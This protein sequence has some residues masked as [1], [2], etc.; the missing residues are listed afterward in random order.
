MKKKV[1]EIE[2]LSIKSLLTELIKCLE[3][4]SINIHDKKILQELKLPVD[5]IELGTTSSSI[6]DAFHENLVRWQE[7]FDKE[8]PIDAE[9]R[10]K[11]VKNMLLSF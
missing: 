5:L 11:H 2:N 10:L 9:L 1:Q 6:D 8:L 3:K 4:E 7:I